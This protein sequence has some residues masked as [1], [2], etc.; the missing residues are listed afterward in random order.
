MLSRQ[1]ELARQGE[2][3][4]SV[5]V[6]FGVAAWRLES[7][8]THVAPAL[9]DGPREPVPLPVLAQCQVTLEFVP[10]ER[11]PGFEPRP[12]RQFG[13]GSKGRSAPRPLAQ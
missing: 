7:D 10:V 2:H 9:R 5:V 1:V 11:D 6:V 13:I 4:A 12:S 3:D 8:R